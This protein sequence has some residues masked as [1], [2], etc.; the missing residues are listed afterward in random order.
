MIKTE[1]LDQPVIVSLVF[2]NYKKI[3]RDILEDIR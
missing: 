1:H 3:F 2:N